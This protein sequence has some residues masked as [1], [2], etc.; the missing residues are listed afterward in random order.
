MLTQNHFRGDTVVSHVFSILVV[1][2][3]SLNIWCT[4][5][6]IRNSVLHKLK[7]LVIIKILRDSFGKNF[8][9]FVA[10]FQQVDAAD[11]DS[12]LFEWTTRSTYNLSLG[13]QVNTYFYL[14]GLIPCFH[15][16]MV[17]IIPEVGRPC[18]IIMH[19]F[20]SD[21]KLG[22]DTRDGFQSVVKHFGIIMNNISFIRNN[23]HFW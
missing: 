2:F 7:F 1:K 15:F 17:V 11:Q 10:K 6:R 16:R 4:E 19:S 18:K 22:A 3:I 14:R 23:C 5:P 20:W 12:T 8:A 13:M 21:I 9:L